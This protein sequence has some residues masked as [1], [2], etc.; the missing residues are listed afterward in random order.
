MLL[1]KKKNDFRPVALEQVKQFDLSMDE[2]L[3]AE[4][5][6]YYQFDIKKTPKGKL[7][8][9]IYQSP[10]LKLLVKA[11]GQERYY[12]TSPGLLKTGLFA[13]HFVSLTADFYHL[14]QNDSTGKKADL[15]AY[16]VHPVVPS[17]FRKE[18]RVT[19]F[20]IK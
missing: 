2:D 16:S 7:I 18:I 5:D 13:N 9:L 12:R 14:I 6:H 19:Q 8:S 4:A 3:F 11:H 20:K 17:R 1:L 10:A 15:D